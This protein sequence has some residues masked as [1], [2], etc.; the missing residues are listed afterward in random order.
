MSRGKRRGGY[1][2]PSNPA[3]VSPPGANSKRTDGSPTNPMPTGQPYGARKDLEAFRATGMNQ[4]QPL[5]TATGGGAVS[6]A[7]PR[8]PVNLD[9]FAPTNRPGEPVTA[10]IPYGPGSNGPILPRDPV[11]FLRAMYAIDADPDILEVLM[12]FGGQV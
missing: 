1:Q 4:A 11:E 5:P 10:G 3:S 2:K 6:P 7:A 8:A 12:D 9:P